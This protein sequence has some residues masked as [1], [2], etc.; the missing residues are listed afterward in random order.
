[1]MVADFKNYSVDLAEELNANDFVAGIEEA[2]EK[3]K[4]VNRIDEDGSI[5]S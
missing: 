2:W 5:F 1:M 4:T 3:L